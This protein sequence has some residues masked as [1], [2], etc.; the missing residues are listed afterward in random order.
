MLFL[1]L[2][3]PTI[4]SGCV[5][6]IDQ[7]T[8]IIRNQTEASVTVDLSVTDA[9]NHTVGFE[10]TLQIAAS[11]RA[12]LGD[13]TP[14]SAD[15]IV[16]VSVEGGPAAEWPLDS[17]DACGSCILNVWISTESVTFSQDVLD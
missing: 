9:A 12:K 10:K 14:W 15:F 6:G 11:S 8:T 2:V 16:N 13:I 4:S 5:I 1:A 7:F 17:G 3:A